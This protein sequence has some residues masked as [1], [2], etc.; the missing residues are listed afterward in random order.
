VDVA[1]ELRLRVRAGRHDFRTRG[2]EKNVVESEGFRNR[3]MNH[4]LLYGTDRIPAISIATEF[5]DFHL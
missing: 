5:A 1:G 4:V 2:N 3:E